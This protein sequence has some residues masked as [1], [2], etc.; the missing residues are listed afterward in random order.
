MYLPWSIIDSIYYTLTHRLPFLLLRLM[1]YHLLLVMFRFITWMLSST[2]K[3][4][5]IAIDYDEDLRWKI[6][7]NFMPLKLHYRD[8]WSGRFECAFCVLAGCSFDE[9]SCLNDDCG[10]ILLGHFFINSEIEKSSKNWDWNLIKKFFD[11][12]SQ[13]VRSI[14]VIDKIVGYF[15]SNMRHSRG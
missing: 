7:C 13:Q 1:E 9:W 2:G 12:N 15:S 3:L 4:N 10:R 6:L 8:C 11:R 14:L 5:L